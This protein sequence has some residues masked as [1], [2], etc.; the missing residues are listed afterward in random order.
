MAKVTEAERTHDA[1]AASTQGVSVRVTPFYLP[2]Q[3]DADAPR[4]VWA[5]TVE[6]ANEGQTRVQLRER[7]WRITDG[8]GAVEH[9][10]GPGVVGE[11]PVLGPGERFEYTSGCP[12]STPSGFMEGYYTM[13]RE[14]GETFEAAIP[15]FSLDLP[16]AGRVLN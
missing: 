12:L 14:D 11:Q 3:S 8:N 9:V 4:H 15:A 13:V 6:I 7:S 1:F 2:E 16:G 10:R 5:Y